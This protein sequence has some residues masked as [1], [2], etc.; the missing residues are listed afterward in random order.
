MDHTSEA[1]RIWR[2][3]KPMIDEEIKKQTASCIRAKKMAVTSAPN[4]TTI[5][6]AEPFGNSIQIP[7][8]SSLS[9]VSTGDAVWVWWF[10]GNASTMI[11]MTTGEGQLSK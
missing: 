11:A 3:L 2:N 4:G 8:S 10:Y 6:V 9:G 1:Q 5:G 7:Y